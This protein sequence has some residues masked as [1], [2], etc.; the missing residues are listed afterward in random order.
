MDQDPV[1]SPPMPQ[2]TPDLSPRQ[3]LLA[4]QKQVFRQNQRLI[5]DSI[6]VVE[7]GFEKYRKTYLGYVRKFDHV[8]TPEEL[9]A[10]IA[11]ADIIYVGDYHTNPQ[12]QRA[13]L[14]VLKMAAQ[15]GFRLS[16]ALEL[17]HRRYQPEIERFL[18]SKIEEET[19]LKKIHLT[20]RWY[21]D[22]WKNFQP[23]FDFAKYHQFKV[24]GVES[25][26]TRHSTLQSRDQACAE[27]LVKILSQNPEEKLFVLIGDLH[28]AP[29]HLP[30]KVSR[31]LKKKKLKKKE[32]FLYQNSEQIY[33]QLAAMQEEEKAEIVRIDARSF[34]IMNTPPIVWQ[35]SYI[36]WLEHEEGEIDFSDAK[37]SF[38]ELVDRIAGFLG[39]TLP[40]EKEEV[41]VYTCGDL[42]FL[43]R[44]EKESDFSRQDIQRIKKQIRASES[45]YIPKKK[46]AYLGSL[47]LNHVAEEASH[48]IRHLCAGDEFPRDPVDAFY[49]N[50]LHEALGF[51]G[52]KMI[53]HH[54]KCLH[55]KDFERIL[56]FFRD[57]THVPKDRSLELDVAHLVL[58]LKA[59][60]KQGKLIS[61]AKVIQ[62]HDA[63]FF[64]VTHALGY[65]LGDRLFYALMAGKISKDEIYELYYN[66]FAE[67]GDPGWVYQHLLQ[68]LRKIRLPRRV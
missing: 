2:K 4:L 22:L 61:S 28:L 10:A 13:F 39:M 18:A 59:L 34:C 3:E 12:S 11:E 57:Q 58:E 8:A 46:I 60:E 23:L 20:R 36:N 37:A 65:M 14:R 16:V 21:F 9:Q 50:A 6:S 56:F 19:F 31:L 67:S 1:E 15:T 63:L 49:A 38:L 42:S 24:Y 26:H 64:A 5:E 51:L 32:L 52:S 40:K 45:Y 68:R 55:E 30:V 29:P 17:I 7:K 53:N 62:Q 25:A 66:P 54:R 43:E 27:L 48:F 35:Q 41:E 33:W 47:S 44:L